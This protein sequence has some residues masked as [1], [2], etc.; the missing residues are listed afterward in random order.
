MGLF[1]LHRANNLP[2]TDKAHLPFKKP[3]LISNGNRQRYI[4]SI[5]TEV[6]VRNPKTIEKSRILKR[7]SVAVIIN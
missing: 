6:K 4:P 2:N 5:G 3:L 1:D 7:N